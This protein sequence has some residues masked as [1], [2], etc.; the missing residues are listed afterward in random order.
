MNEKIRSGKSYKDDNVDGL[1]D[2]D[3]AAKYLG[4][5]KSSLYRISMR[6][7]ITKV[8][9]GRLNKFRKNDLDTFI[10]K[11]TIEAENLL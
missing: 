10:D 6:K 4:I 8:K 2:M 5:K 11:N 3:T 9:I 7:E 1:I